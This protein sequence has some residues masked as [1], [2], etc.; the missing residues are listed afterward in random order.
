MP[1][2]KR[3]FTR[4]VKV[5][6]NDN[7][8]PTPS[9]KE[10]VA[11]DVTIVGITDDELDIV[12]GARGHQNLEDTANC[13]NV[14][15]HEKVTSDEDSTI[16]YTSDDSDGEK[17]TLTAISMSPTASVLLQRAKKRE[18][19]LKNQIKQ[20]KKDME[21]LQRQLAAKNTVVAESEKTTSAS[22]LS[23]TSSSSTTPS[24]SSSS[25]S[26]SSED[27][28][29]KRRKKKHLNKHAKKRCIQKDKK[30]S[31]QKKK[32]AKERTS[33]GRRGES[34]VIRSI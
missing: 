31:R 15:V 2:K 24:S 22:S 16:L 10:T 25:S 21:S 33:L 11:P 13:S 30:K 17:Q 18:G 29:K 3:H 8:F 4:S 9:T 14:N 23:S 6:G 26:S 1:G 12:A 7:K 28:K 27:K 32:V 20:L 19:L 34:T 5:L